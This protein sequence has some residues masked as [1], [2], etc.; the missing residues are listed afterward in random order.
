MTEMSFW[1]ATGCGFALGFIVCLCFV[2]H[3]LRPDQHQK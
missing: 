1:L 3:L 2:A